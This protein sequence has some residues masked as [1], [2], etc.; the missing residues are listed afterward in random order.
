M[1]T[2]SI[3]P[4]NHFSGEDFCVDVG[5]EHESKRLKCDWDSGHVEWN[6]ENPIAPSEGASS[7]SRSQQMGGPD[8]FEE[9]KRALNMALKC[10]AESEPMRVLECYEQYNKAQ[11]R[12]PF[13]YNTSFIGGSIGHAHSESQCGHCNCLGRG[14]IRCV[15]EMPSEK[16]HGRC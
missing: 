1:D 5:E 10:E 13:L 2:E 12:S 3:P 7:S 14:K 8:L 11:V 6:R 16:T 4:E 15:E 9:V